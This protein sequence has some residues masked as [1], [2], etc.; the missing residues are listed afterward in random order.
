M[1]AGPEEARGEDSSSGLDVDRC[2]TASGPLSTSRLPCSDSSSAVW[3]VTKAG[4][5][6]TLG[7]QWEKASLWELVKGSWELISGHL[8]GGGFSRDLRLGPDK[9]SAWLWS[10]DSLGL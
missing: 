6:L 1:Q 4:L 5:A 7:E 9:G 10:F 3:E 8:G 2:C